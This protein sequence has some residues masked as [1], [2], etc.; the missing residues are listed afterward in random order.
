MTLRLLPAVIL[1]SF[2]S[3]TQAATIN[4]VIRSMRTNPV[5]RCHPPCN[6]HR[7][8]T[9]FNDLLI[10][11][12]NGTWFT[13]ACQQATLLRVNPLGNDAFIQEHC[14]ITSREFGGS[15]VRVQVDLLSYGARMVFVEV[16]LHSRYE[17]ERFRRP[18]V[19]SQTFPK[20]QLY[21][22]RDF[23]KKYCWNTD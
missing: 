9:L 14:I 22:I 17:P 15:A 2:L 18:Y 19:L 7:V 4:S 10:I 13:G 21:L 23:L 3:I 16:P 5:N 6:P 1:L 8:R 20:S 12:D 11:C